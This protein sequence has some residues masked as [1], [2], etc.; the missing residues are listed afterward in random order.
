MRFV[1]L[2][3][4]FVITGSLVLL[5]SGSVAATNGS[6]GGL[7]GSTNAVRIDDL[8][9][10]LSP[11]KL[12]L[13]FNDPGYDDRWNLDPIIGLFDTDISI[14][15]LNRMLGGSSAYPP[16]LGGMRALGGPECPWPG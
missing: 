3:A 12:D 1:S 7:F 6:S 10:F 15:D 8:N 9:T 14:G 2:L 4:A 13:N 16:M 5:A 11:R